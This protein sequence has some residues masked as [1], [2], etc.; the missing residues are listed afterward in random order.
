[1]EHS[2]VS[3]K[4]KGGSTK[5]QLVNQREQPANLYIPLWIHLGK[6]DIVGEPSALS[7]HT[8]IMKKANNKKLNVGPLMRPRPGERGCEQ[9][10]ASGPWIEPDSP[11]ERGYST[12]HP[13]D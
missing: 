9:S 1:M 3:R 12:W 5:H 13:L 6:V 4:P 2:P 7:A 8:K 10:H 11:K